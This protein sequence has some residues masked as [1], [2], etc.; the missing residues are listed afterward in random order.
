MTNRALIESMCESR[1]IKIK[2]LE[3]IRCRD[4]AYG[5]SWDSSYW[6]LTIYLTEHVDETYDT[7]LGDNISG[8]ILLMFDQI[9]KDIKEL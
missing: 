5:D 8:G 7:T 6:E 4:Y 2:L 9:D 3:Y 1:G